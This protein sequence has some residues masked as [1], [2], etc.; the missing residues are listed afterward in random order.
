MR[1]AEG[2]HMLV[3]AGDSRNL[4][5]VVEVAGMHAVLAVPERPVEGLFRT[6]RRSRIPVAAA[7]GP[8]EER[9]NRAAAAAAAAAGKAIVPA[10]DSPVANTPGLISLSAFV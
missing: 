5:A 8:A 4:V 10:A 1:P 7:A 2:N 9:P 6:E 3:A